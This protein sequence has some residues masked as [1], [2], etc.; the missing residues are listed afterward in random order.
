MRRIMSREKEKWR[1]E[2]IDGRKLRKRGR[3]KR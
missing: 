3:E 1:E 2:Q